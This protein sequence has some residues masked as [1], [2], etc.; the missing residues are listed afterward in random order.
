MTREVAA[1]IE[2]DLIGEPQEGIKLIKAECTPSQVMIR[3]PESKIKDGMKVKT[4]PINQSLY[5]E[6]IE[7]LADLLLPDS[8]LSLVD[9]E[10]KVTVRLIVE[11]E[12]TEEGENSPEAK[13]KAAAKKKPPIKKDT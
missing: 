10:T 5:T 8:D 2:V 3:G 7:I 9:T 1:E 12:E 11:I 13:D 6:S 4:T